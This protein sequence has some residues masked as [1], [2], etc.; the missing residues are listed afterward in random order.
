MIIW[1]LGN[2]IKGRLLIRH[3][4]VGL[5]TVIFIV[6]SS[7]HA[8]LTEAVDEFFTSISEKVQEKQVPVLVLANKQDSSKVLSPEEIKQAR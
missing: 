5:D 2:R 1:D 8:R 4:V 7:D 3:Y 6:D